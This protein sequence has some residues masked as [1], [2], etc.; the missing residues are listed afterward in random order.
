M[1]PAHFFFIHFCEIGKTKKN[2]RL[3]HLVFIFLGDV[4]E[5]TFFSDRTAH[6]EM[7]FFCLV[8]YPEVSFD[9]ASMLFLCTCRLIYVRTVCWIFFLF[10]NCLKMTPFTTFT[11]TSLLEV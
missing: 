4:C 1:V 3:L 6:D 5:C 8:K 11:L 9:L 2:R 10:E 7:I